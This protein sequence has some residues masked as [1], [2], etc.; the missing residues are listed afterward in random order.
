[1]FTA[2]ERSGASTE[3]KRT[4]CRMVKFRSKVPIGGQPSECGCAQFSSKLESMAVMPHC[5][6]LNSFVGTVS[7]HARNNGKCWQ[8]SVGWTGVFIMRKILSIR[9]ILETVSLYFSANFSI[10]QTPG[11]FEHDKEPLVEDEVVEL[12]S[13]SLFHKIPT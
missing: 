12:V 10:S 5:W 9:S 7:D 6:W 11:K 13:I 4:F 3:S 1:M 2:C 8:F